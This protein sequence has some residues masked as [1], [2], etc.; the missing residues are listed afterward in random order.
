M[1][2]WLQILIVI[3]IA[4]GVYYGVRTFRA[5]A[6]APT[7]PTVSARRGTFQVTISVRGSLTPA[8]SVQINAPRISGLIIS[9]LV[10]TGSLVHQGDV[11]ATFDSGSARDTQVTDLA[12]LNQTKA[13]LAQIGAQAKITD[14]QDQL[15]LATDTNAVA[16]AKLQV[17]L[18]SVQSAVQG[19]EA[20]LALGMAEEKL[21]VEKATIQSHQAS[22]SAQ[23][24]TDLRSE[25]K[26]QADYDLISK[27]ID[28]MTVHA[29]ITGHIA[30]L[31]NHANGHDNEAPFK[32]GDS[33]WGNGAF[34]EIPDMST[35]QVLAKVSEVTRGKMLVGQPIRMTLDAL[36][37]LPIRG[38]IVTISALTEP[39][40]GATWPPPQVFRVNAS[41]DHISPRMQPAMNGSVDV[42]T[43]RIPNAIIV[44]AEAIF[45]IEG[46]PNVYVENGDHF[47]A[48]AVTVLART[49]DNAAVSGLDAGT[50]IAL[51]QPQPDKIKH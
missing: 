48:K 36:P 51:K 38:N 10:P 50:R 29:P 15:D 18:M 12:T 45:P 16:K 31:M 22:N 39:D 28:Q 13:Q 20:K 17:I 43:K 3:V 27:Q 41:I 30:Y 44:P 46:K 35:L 23:I 2:R 34:A 21:K 32:V 11:I 4:G 47:Q 37:E 14:Q 19:K 33:V 1:K 7:V 9:T 40:F 42:V 5:R 24:A 6:M 8:R 49:A 26:A 25:Q